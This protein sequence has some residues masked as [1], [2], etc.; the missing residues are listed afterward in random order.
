MNNTLTA[1]DGV[2]VGHATHPAAL[3]GCTAVVFDRPFS[4]AVKAYGG[5]AGGFNLEGLRGGHTDYGV[6]GLFIAGGSST[7]LLAGAG[8]M[9]A[10][11]ADG[12]GAKSGAAGAIINPSVSG[13]AIYDL[14]MEV[15]PFSADYGREAYANASSDPVASGNVG[16]GT[17]ASVGKYRWLDLGASNPAMKGGVGSAR[18]DVGGGIIVCAMSVVNAVGNVVLPSGQILAGNR[19]EH[20]DFSSYEELSDFLTRAD[21]GRSEH[22]TTI[23]V[24]G[25]NV[26]LGALEHY[27]KVAHF[28]THGQVRAINPVHTAGDGDTV[29]VFSNGQL[30][31]P[32]NSTAQFFKESATDI[33][34]QVD[35]IG[36]AAARAVQESIY[37]ACRSATTVQVEGAYGG[38]V[39]GAA[40]YPI[41]QSAR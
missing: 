5:G 27:E 26:D 29:F 13:A 14:G 36:H 10:M 1:L 38:V 37:D 24:V 39:P 8:M 6:G 3:T 30:R 11:R 21:A 15:A 40:D 19:D 33:H 34:L 41:G 9:E 22:N 25:I 32:L 23:T 35:L 12:L 16:A 4:T 17:G 18:V 2:R 31:D 20:G 28:A 7:G